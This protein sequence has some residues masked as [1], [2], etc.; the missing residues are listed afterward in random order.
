MSFMDVLLG[1]HEADLLVCHVLPFLDLRSLAR[2]GTTSRSIHEATRNVSLSGRLFPNVLSW[3]YARTMHNL[4]ALVLFARSSIVVLPNPSVFP[5][6]DPA[7]LPPEVAQSMTT[8]IRSPPFVSS[9]TTITTKREEHK[10]LV[11]GMRRAYNRRLLSVDNVRRLNRWRRFR[12]SKEAF[13][14]LYGHRFLSSAQRQHVREHP[15]TQQLRLPSGPCVAGVT[16]TSS[17]NT[18]VYHFQPRRFARPSDPSVVLDARL[19]PPGRAQHVT[20]AEP[21]FAPPRFFNGKRVYGPEDEDRVVIKYKHNGRFRG[22][23]SG[24]TGILYHVT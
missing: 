15:C 1:G 18:C 8:W 22:W 16:H 3:P 4:A 9:G 14:A 12:G 23:V 20:F 7:L 21:V 10:E 2:L 5:H 19:V 24:A 6:V 13:E 11:Q 17:D